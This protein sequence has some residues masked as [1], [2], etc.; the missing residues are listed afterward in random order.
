MQLFRLTLAVLVSVYCISGT[1][2]ISPK[3]GSLI[4]AVRVGF[5]N[6]AA[7][8][9]Y[10]AELV[11]ADRERFRPIMIAAKHGLGDLVRRLAEN[12]ENS[13][14]TLK[15]ALMMAA[16]NGHADIVHYLLERD[17]NLMHSTNEGGYS[18]A[19]L[20]AGKYDG[21]ES[22]WT[23]N[24]PLR[25]A[26]RNGHLDVIKTLVQHG[27]SVN[28][29]ELGTACIRSS[30]DIIKFLID[31][32]MDINGPFAN[33]LNADFP[34]YA[35]DVA[36]E[37]HRIDVFKLLIK[38]GATLRLSRAIRHVFPNPEMRRLLLENGADANIDDGILLYS[39][40]VRDSLDAA[41]LLVKHG[42]RLITDQRGRNPLKKAIRKNKREFVELFIEAGLVKDLEMP[43][44]VTDRQDQAT[45]I[46]AGARSTVD[47]QLALNMIMA[48]ILSTERARS[49]KIW[50]ESI[51]DRVNIMRLRAAWGPQAFIYA[52]L[53]KKGGYRSGGDYWEIPSVITF[54]FQARKR[55]DDLLSNR[56]V[57]EDFFQAWTDERLGM[58]SSITSELV[59]LECTDIN[60]FY[61]VSR[62]LAYADDDML[63]H[64][65][66]AFKFLGRSRA[67]E[68]P[69]RAK[70]RDVAA[71]GQILNEMIERSSHIG[72]RPVVK[73]LYGIYLE[74]LAFMRAFTA[75]GLPM[76][77][78]DL[79][80][81]HN[82]DPAYRN[83][84]TKAMEKLMQ[85]IGRLERE[86]GQYI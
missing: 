85:A 63:R 56:F 33:S 84:R 79:V 20:T 37:G 6:V 51:K 19:E 34:R 36:V 76:E 32:V 25:M 80:M 4:D 27:A 69:A 47:S 15:K 83:L 3:H 38:H 29:A 7:R 18:S 78:A 1:E 68:R 86:V 73:A 66:T 74:E 13:T 14:D 45:L 26:V 30:I 62:F 44:Y 40:V 21:P 59:A 12:G 50:G 52:S 17:V 41:R 55:G 46:L 77:L 82:D 49:A 22:N 60:F 8:L 11:R 75:D 57:R 67:S 42:A 58:V 24:S 71:H 31:N 16:F 9:K 2:A 70:D 61:T 28:S 54:A 65:E 53:R 64:A 39:A 10:E 72:L 35:I 81:S 5:T 48:P 23:G 43:S